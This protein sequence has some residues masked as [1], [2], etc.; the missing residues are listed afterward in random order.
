MIHRNVIT[1]TTY[2]FLHTTSVIIYQTFFDWDKSNTSIHYVG[3]ALKGTLSHV[4]WSSGCKILRPMSIGKDH[5]GN[6]LISDP[7]EVDINPVDKK[8]LVGENVTFCCQIT[9]DPA[10]KYYEWYVRLFL[11]FIKQAKKY[12]FKSVL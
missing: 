8:R 4:Y 12:Y 6:I 2:D 3:D 1:Y 5:S 7:L 9:G 10:P 11:Q